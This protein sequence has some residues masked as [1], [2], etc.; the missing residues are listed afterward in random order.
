MPGA[1]FS[2]LGGTGSG[3]AGLDAF[4]AT[5]GSVEGDGTVWL[6][7]VATGMGADGS[8][9]ALELVLSATFERSDGARARL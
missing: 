8:G 6:T 4:G 9:A 1:V 7:I 3:P 5:C 2:V